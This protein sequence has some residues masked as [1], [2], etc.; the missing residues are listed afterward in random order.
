MS[1]V[2]AAISIDAPPQSVFDLVMDPNRLADWVTI[3]RSVTL[4]SASAQE[5]GATMDQVLSMRGVSITVHWTLV[6]AIPP[7]EAEWQGRGPAGARAFIRYRISGPVEG[8]TRFEYTNDFSTPGGRI[9]LAAS[10]V[11]VG[12]ASEREARRSLEKL[13]ALM[14]N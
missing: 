2:T 9:G 7:R 1:Q 10:K 6:T 8:P 14:E 5:P 4:T 13:K 11:I 12:S 3:H